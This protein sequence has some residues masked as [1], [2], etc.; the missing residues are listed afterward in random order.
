VEVVLKAIM[1]CE[2]AC[3]PD[4]CKKAITLANVS[5]I[6]STCS[7]VDDDDD[8]DIDGDALGCLCTRSGINV[9]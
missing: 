4:W 1:N 8:D 3:L 7:P 9:S 5:F 6:L 2:V